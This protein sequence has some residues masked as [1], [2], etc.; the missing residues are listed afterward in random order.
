[1][2][3]D[4]S[5][6]TVHD[7]GTLRTWTA[8]AGSGVPGGGWECLVCRQWRSSYPDEQAALAAGRQHRDIWCAPVLREEMAAQRARC[9]CDRSQEP[10]PPSGCHRWIRGRLHDDRA[11][12]AGTEVPR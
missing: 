3:A 11:A 10:C 4:L 7:G 8:P 5:W 6:G 9:G 2:T 1:M 12:L